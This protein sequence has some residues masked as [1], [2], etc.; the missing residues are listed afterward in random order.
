VNE[1]KE[2]RY[3]AS[4]LRA[5]VPRLSEETAVAWSSVI[6]EAKGEAVTVLEA[7]E[8]GQVIEVPRERFVESEVRAGVRDY[9]SQLRASEFPCLRDI[10][11]SIRAVRRNAVIVAQKARPALPARA[12]LTEE[13]ATANKREARIALAYV[14]EKLGIAG[15]GRSMPEPMGLPVRPVSS[16]QLKQAEE[17]RRE[18]R[19][20]AARL[21]EVE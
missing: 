5:F 4:M 15:I 12:S 2:L 13:Q 17:R 8:R 20:Q 11:D 18:L 19:A 10:L 3:V 9:A 1:A 6:L 21:V 16:E 7:D 14:R